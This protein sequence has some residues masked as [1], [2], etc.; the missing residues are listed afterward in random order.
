M[1]EPVRPGALPK[2]CPAALGAFG[3]PARR[4][5]TRA[6]VFAMLEKARAFL[7]SAPQGVRLQDAAAIAGLSPYHFARTFRDTYGASPAAYHRSLLVARA[8]Q[9]L[10]HLSVG[11]VATELGYQSVSA[12]SRMYRS[13]TGAA[14]SRSGRTRRGQAR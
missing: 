1:D 9:L 5:S 2:P 10:Q 3:V 11:E 7:E 13:S 12:F 4:W 6:D 8:G 14:P